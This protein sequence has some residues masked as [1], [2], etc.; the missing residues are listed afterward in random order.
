VRKK[1][2]Y[3]FSNTKLCEEAAHGG[4]G[5]IRTARVEK[6]EQ[7]SAFNFIDLTE[8]PP[9]SSIGVHTHSYDDEEVYVIIS[10]KGRMFSDGVFFEVGAGDVIVNHPGGTHSLE[11]TGPDTLRMI[12]LDAPVGE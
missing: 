1:R 3:N 9:G 4:K 10:G 2:F 12:V 7:G 6:K 8:I 5:E 11:N